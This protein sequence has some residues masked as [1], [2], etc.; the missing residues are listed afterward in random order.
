MQSLKYDFL[1]SDPK[2]IAETA[3]RFTLGLPGVGTMIVGTKNPKRW[4]ENAE[5]VAKGTLPPEQFE[6]IRARWAEVAEASWV[7]LT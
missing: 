5:I 4:H 7:G 3:L 2:T 1:A 6:A